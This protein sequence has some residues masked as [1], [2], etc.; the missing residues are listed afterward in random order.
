MDVRSSECS[1]LIGIAPE[2]KICMRKSADLLFS[3]VSGMFLQTFRP[4][5]LQLLRK[6][7][8]KRKDLCYNIEDVVG[9]LCKLC[10][11]SRKKS[12]RGF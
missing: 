4:F 9:E 8:A 2:G 7:L 10:I 12:F 3:F 1:E 11:L 5:F 6:V